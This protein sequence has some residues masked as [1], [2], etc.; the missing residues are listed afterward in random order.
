MYNL[1]EYSHNYLMTSES[2]FN[3]YRDKID[4]V[5]NNAS[6][7]KSFEYKTKIEG[8]IPETLSQ[9]GF[10]GDVDQPPQPPVPSVNVEVALPLKYRSN[11]TRSFDLTLINFEVEL[12]LLWK[13]DCLLIGYYNSITDVDFKI[14]SCKFYVIVVT[15]CINDN[16]KFLEHLKQ[17][18]RRTIYWN[19]YRSEITTQSKNNNLD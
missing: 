3:Y 6:D 14:I 18:F 15:L 1:L 8:K 12:D 19:K 13:K 17:G 16:I 5:D 7:G 2:L 11:F 10:S 4:E 9:S